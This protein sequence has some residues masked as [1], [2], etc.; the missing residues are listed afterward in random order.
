MSKRFADD[1]G[2]G[3]QAYLKRQK[4]SNP[5][6]TAPTGPEEE[7]RSGKQLRQLLSFSQDSGRSRHGRLSTVQDLTVL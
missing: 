5:V 2:D 3:N 7:I 4:L 6:N 1:G